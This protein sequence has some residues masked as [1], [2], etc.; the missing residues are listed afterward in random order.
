[1]KHEWARCNSKCSWKCKECGLTKT[2]HTWV[3]MF[4]DERPIARFVKCSRCGQL[5][6]NQHGPHRPLTADSAHMMAEMI[7]RFEERQ[8]ICSYMVV[9]DKKIWFDYPEQ[10]AW[11]LATIYNRAEEQIVYILKAADLL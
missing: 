9:D 11:A 4:E 10:T 5:K 7:K 1:M 3:E 8:D 6:D 2:E